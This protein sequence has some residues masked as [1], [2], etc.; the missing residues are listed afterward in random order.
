M[1]EP[2]SCNLSMCTL[3]FFRNKMPIT[4][5]P[6][7]VKK[8]RKRISQPNPLTSASQLNLLRDG[9]LEN[10]RKSSLRLKS[11]KSLTLDGSMHD[12]KNAFKSMLPKKDRIANDNNIR[13]SQK[14]LS[15]MTRILRN[16]SSATETTVANSCISSGSGS[17]LLNASVDENEDINLI[18]HFPSSEGDITLKSLNNSAL[19]LSSVRYDSG[20]TPQSDMEDVR[21]QFPKLK[22]HASLDEAVKAKEQKLISLDKSEHEM[23]NKFLSLKSQNGVSGSLALEDIKLQKDNR[24]ES[25]KDELNM[26]MGRSDDRSNPK[27]KFTKNAVGTN[28]S[29]KS[30]RGWGFSSAHVSSLG[31]DESNDLRSSKSRL[32]RMR[33]KNISK[34]T[35]D[36]LGMSMGSSNGNI[37]LKSS[38]SK[39]ALDTSSS[40]K[41]KR[42][43]GFSSL[44]VS[45]LGFDASNDLRSSK[46]FL[47]GM[48]QK[49][50]SKSTK[51]ELDMSMRSSEGKR[52]FKSRFS[53]NSLEISSSDKPK[54]GWGFSSLH[55]SILGVEESDGLRS[56][57][58]RLNGNVVAD[59]LRS[60]KSFRKPRE[61]LWRQK[62]ETVGQPISSS[63]CIVDTALRP[64]QTGATGEVCISAS[65]VIDGYM[66]D[67]ESNRKSF[68]FLAGTKWF[69]YG[70][71][72]DYICC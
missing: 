30:K 43:W 24:N 36:E 45:S 11:H 14:D 58:S 33:Q 6:V 25:T 38:V 28:S 4:Q 71:I 56:S 51:D 35:K 31:F 49:N 9:Q 59:E 34:S 64:I 62:K 21:N 19:P 37:S 46:S 12:L 65:T 1:T 55:I 63:L 44:H 72:L 18:Q 57:K 26:S 39:N 3:I 29:N 67:K 22:R 2:L 40:N 41:S 5:V 60:S 70:F 15:D 17:K 53:K 16:T 48:R 10:P 66:Q 8:V 27:S 50:I 20:N 61:A 47:N 23:K 42:G 52:S 68:F 54:K 32:N 13:A 69:R 7:P